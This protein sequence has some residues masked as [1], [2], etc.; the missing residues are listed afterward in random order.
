M[1]K[2]NIGLMKGLGSEVCF[3]IISYTNK[4][5]EKLR[6]IL[7]RSRRIREK[8]KF[9]SFPEYSNFTKMVSCY[10]AKEKKR[11]EGKASFF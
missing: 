3:G 5:C 4:K 7:K 2:K 9:S 8:K 6:K 10:Q 11:G 1:E